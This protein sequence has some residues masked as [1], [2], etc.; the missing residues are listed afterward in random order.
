[1]YAALPISSDLTLSA[2]GGSIG[3]QTYSGTEESHSK[4]VGAAG[5]VLTVEGERRTLTLSNV[6]HNDVTGSPTC[7][8]ASG[9]TPISVD[10]LRVVQARLRA[11][12]PL[13]AGNV[14]ST[15]SK[16][17]LTSA[18]S[19]IVSENISLASSTWE[20]AG[21]VEASAWIASTGT[22]WNSTSR[23]VG[24]S[25][26]LDGTKNVW[27]MTALNGSHSLSVARGSRID[28]ID[29]STTLMVHAG[30]ALVEGSINLRKL[31]MTCAG[32]L[33]VMGS[34]A[35]INATGQGYA[36]HSGTGAGP[37]EASTAGGW[38][39]THGG[40]GGKGDYSQQTSAAN[41]YGSYETP[42]MAGSG[43]GRGIFRYS[44]SKYYN[45]GG[46]GG[47]VISI[48]VAGTM[49]LASGATIQAN[50]HQGEQGIYSTSTRADYSGGGG[51]AGGSVL[52]RASSVLGSGGT[53]SARGGQGGARG[54]YSS[55][56]WRNG[57][58]GGGGGR[59]AVYAGMQDSV[60][61]S[62][63]GG[64]PGSSYSHSGSES[65]EGTFNHVLPSPNP[66]S[67][68]PPPPFPPGYPPPPPPCP[69]P[70]PSPPPPPSPSPPRLPYPL[71]PPMPPPLEFGATVRIP[72]TGGS[73]PR[74]VFMSGQHVCEITM[75][76]DIGL[77]TSCAL[78]HDSTASATAETQFDIIA[79]GTRA[80][81]IVFA[82]EG[83]TCELIM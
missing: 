31:E 45:N 2:A 56:S 79:V 68:L 83:R 37:D 1:M 7:L 39:G 14:T 76:L 38:G 50:G 78:G 61:V 58:G 35:T 36:T 53:I 4:D 64:L 19:L 44:T 80:P 33:T 77:S 22:A 34:G 3:P 18:S 20:T 72:S 25:I 51:G 30:E 11:T 62:V 65:C 42:S 8:C 48:T 73:A 24:R 13:V 74:V 70:S 75:G 9:S 21:V 63:A 32:T 17:E 10:E 5:T 16:V 67:P 47:G 71:P 15:S 27:A 28:Q 41:A 59:V 55:S 66:P 69:P 6:P 46:A 12:Q 23:V 60:I 82:R 40:H 81:R 49:Q 43:G 29:G 57:G 26:V 52:I 54:R